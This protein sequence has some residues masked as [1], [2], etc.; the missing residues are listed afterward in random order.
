MDIM[1]FNNS[2]YL[3]NII[4]NINELVLERNSKSCICVCT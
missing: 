3:T 1:Y 4:C 2:V